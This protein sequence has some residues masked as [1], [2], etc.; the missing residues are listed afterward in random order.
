MKKAV[1][2]EADKPTDARCDE[3]LFGRKIQVVKRGPKDKSD[4]IR[5]ECHVARP[6]SHGFPV[7]RCDDWCAFHVS[8]ATHERT[9]NGLAAII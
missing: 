3:C 5:C 8:A 6:T 2:H 9:F 1:I 4:N 7:V